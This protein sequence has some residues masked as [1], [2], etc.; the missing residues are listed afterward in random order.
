[1]SS[2]YT[3]QCDNVPVTFTFDKFT[4]KITDSINTKYVLMNNHFWNKAE[5]LGCVTN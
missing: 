4:V 1:M 5:G 2:P 3:A